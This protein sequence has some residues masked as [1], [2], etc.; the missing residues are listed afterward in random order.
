MKQLKRN[1][2]ERDTIGVARELV[3]KLLDHGG[4]RSRITET[5]AYLGETDPAAHA[6]RKN[7]KYRE[8]FWGRAGL[9]Y[10]FLNYGVH[11]CLNVIT[12]PEG[13]AGCVLFRGIEAANGPGRLTKYLGIS[14]ALNGA[15]FD[16]GPITIWDDGYKVPTL[17]IGPRIGVSK[18]RSERL[19]FWMNSD[20]DH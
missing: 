19:R 20:L 10:V 5:E 3:G 17:S 14:G 4:K 18:A 13:R 7:T 6:A 12:E 1:F 9:A 11:W 8:L 16:S 15:D 2:F